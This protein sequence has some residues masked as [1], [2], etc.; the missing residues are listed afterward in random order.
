MGRARQG[1]YQ[2]SRQYCPAAQSQWQSQ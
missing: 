2:S 1:G